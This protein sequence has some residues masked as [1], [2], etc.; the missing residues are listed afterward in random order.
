MSLPHA[1]QRALGRA[2]RQLRTEAGQTQEDVA[3]AAGIT[4]ASLSRIEVG[5]RNPTWGTVKSIA[6]G[7]GRTLTEVAALSEELELRERR[8]RS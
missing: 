3:H 4:T 2:I 6:T 8:R 1:P 5:S 7:L